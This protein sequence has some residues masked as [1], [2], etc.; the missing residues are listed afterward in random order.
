MDPLPTFWDT[1]CENGGIGA[2]IGEPQPHSE[3]KKWNESGSD[4][5][6]LPNLQVELGVRYFIAL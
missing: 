6:F 5:V 2:G 3:R 1:R 4:A